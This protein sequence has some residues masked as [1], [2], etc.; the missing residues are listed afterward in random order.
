MLRAWFLGCF[1]LLVLAAPA[2]AVVPD[3]RD[4]L[5]VEL[6]H[7]DFADE[8]SPSHFQVAST[9]DLGDGRQRVEISAELT[10]LV[11]ALFDE[12]ALLP[13]FDGSDVGIEVIQ[14]A[15]FPAIAPA[16][17]GGTASSTTPL[18]LELEAAELPQV[19]QDLEDGTVPHEVFATEQPQLRPDVWLYEWTSADD[20]AH[21]NA[22]D[23]GEAPKVDRFG[24][25]PWDST[26]QHSISLYY[27]ASAPA[28]FLVFDPVTESM[29]LRPRDPDQ[30][31][32]IHEGFHYFVVDD[33]E[34]IDIEDAGQKVILTGRVSSHESLIEIYEYAS[35]SSGGE[36]QIDPPVGATRIAELDGL[37]FDDDVRDSFTF[38]IRF[39]GLDFFEGRVTVSGQ[40]HGHA[41]RPWIGVRLRPGETRLQAG[42]DTDV[43]LSAEL[44]AT[45]TFEDA[46]ELPLYDLCFP[47]PDLVFGPISVPTVMTLEQSILAEGRLHAGA[48]VGIQHR[49]QHGYTV[50]CEGEDRRVTCHTEQTRMEESPLALTPPELTSYV[51]GFG[52]VGTRFDATLLVGGAYPECATGSS[53]SLS[54]EVFGRLDID[55]SQDPWWTMGHGGRLVG[56]VGLEAFGFD[57]L[58]HQV[59]LTPRFTGQARTAAG[60]PPPPEDRPRWL[61][62]E[63]QRWM[64]AIDQHESLNQTVAH[65][66]AAPLSTGDLVVTASEAGGYRVLSLD[67]FGALRWQQTWRSTG[68]R[69]PEALAV[70]SDDTV[71]V[72]GSASYLAAL[73]PN[74]DVRWAYDLDFSDGVDPSRGLTIHDVAVVETDDGWEAVIVGELARGDI[75]EDDAAAIRLDADGNVVW[76]RLYEGDAAQELHGV[77][78]THDGGVVAVGWTGPPVAGSNSALAVRLDGTDGALQWA[79]ELESVARGGTLEDVVEG[80]DGALYAVGAASRD[81]NRTGAAYVARVEADGAHATAAL[82]LHDL[83]AEGELD[84]E[85]T[86]AV[87]SSDTPNDTWTGITMVGDGV[88][89]AGRAGVGDIGTAWLARLTPELGVAWFQVLDGPLGDA[90]ASIS[91]TDEALIV[92]GMSRSAVPDHDDEHVL[93]GKV[94]FEGPITLHPR[95]GHL[96][97]R[98]LASGARDGSAPALVSDGALLDDVDLTTTDLVLDSSTDATDTLLATPIAECVFLLTP[99]GHPTT[100]DPCDDADLFAPVVRILAGHDGTYR[101]RDRWPLDVTLFDER[102]IVAS[103]I[104][105]DGVP[106]SGGAELRMSELGVGPHRIAAWAEDAA[107]NRGSDRID[108][109]I[110]DDAD[111]ADTGEPP[112]DGPSEPTGCGCASGAGLSGPWLAAGLLALVARRRRAGSRRNRV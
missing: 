31:T 88:A 56:H 52:Q 80:L 91:A 94:P 37:L 93:V 102:G 66:N 35:F 100:T 101:L 83:D 62:G 109:V 89:I 30:L 84:F 74:G 51:Q 72:A 79:R 60:A 67:R 82:L 103:E 27:P 39:N 33:I 28:E 53:L 20:D 63:D 96:T 65:V 36:S 22:L 55:A 13:I 32:V 12:A 6:S 57:L 46:G 70:T 34:V 15:R 48:A 40:V 24:G 16:G 108:F 77:T 50:T 92:G 85:T 41:L 99:T 112:T 18:I 97:T 43:T 110:V 69:R 59:D 106:A 25:R 3:L 26:P 9:T 47:L 7:L 8:L 14:A 49:I 71:L 19:L 64:V 61:S 38:P 45:G 68:N 75:R 107:G 104:A 95:Y 23:L 4:E 73:E 1:G 44:R 17:P 10:N 2:R 11:G 105:I 81:I 54:G 58:N 111:T 90:F 86:P 21:Q 98:F 76:A 29:F 87:Q 5:R 42:I 78:I